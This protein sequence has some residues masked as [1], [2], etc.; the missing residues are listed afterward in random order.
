MKRQTDDVFYMIIIDLILQVC[1]FGVLFA[2][3][4][5]AI[6]KAKA[7]PFS[8]ADRKVLQDIMKRNGISNITELTDYLT[9]LGPLKDLI[10]TKEFIDRHGGTEQIDKKLSELNRLKG[11]PVCPV[12]ATSGWPHAGKLAR[13]RGTDDRIT[14]LGASPQFHEVLRRIGRTYDSVKELRPKEF[15]TVFSSLKSSECLYSLDLEEATDLVHTRDALSN[16]FYF[17]VIR[18]R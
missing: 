1:F 12:D 17:H 14:V 9:K 2:V 16:I 8:E 10:G 11:K 6:Q 4:Y 18:G 13:V 3:V 15:S 5:G 7:D